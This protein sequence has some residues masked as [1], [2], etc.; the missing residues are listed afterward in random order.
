[1]TNVIYVPSLIW[2]GN[3][4]DLYKVPFHTFGKVKKRHLRLKACEPNSVNWVD[5]AIVNNATAAAS[6]I[7]FMKAAYPLAL[8]WGDTIRPSSASLS[9]A[10]PAKSAF[11]PS[12]LKKRV[13][14]ENE[15]PLQD[16]IEITS[17]NNT[18]AFQA[19]VAKNGRSCIP[20]SSCCFSIV[21]A[22]RSVDFFV[23]SG[24]VSSH[25]DAAMAYGWVDSLQSLLHGFHKKQLANIDMLQ[26]TLQT[27][28]NKGLETQ[29]KELFEAASRGDTRKLRYLFDSGMPVDYMDDTSGDTVLIL[30]SRLGHYDVCRLALHEYQAKNDPHPAFGQTAL[31]V[32]VSSG[33]AK[34]VK[35]ILDTGELGSIF[36]EIFFTGCKSTHSLLL[37]K[38]TES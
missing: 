32:A 23:S 31:Q 24:G 20:H 29:S 9:T 2:T 5:V 4:E 10:S 3:C 1:M 28:R 16:I 7:E 36:T 30:A 8:V 14:E 21:T 13:K 6:D 38:S 22:K 15:I 11:L 18:A 37:L 25:Q 33:H 17:G 26:S 12:P 19:F 35:L 27:I 34:I